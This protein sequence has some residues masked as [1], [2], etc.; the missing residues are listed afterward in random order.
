MTDKPPAS[1]AL[2]KLN[3]PHRV[4]RHAMPVTSFEQAA[5]DRDQRPEQIVRSILFQI[6]PEEFVMVLMA[7]R[8]QVD[9]RKLRKLVGRSRVRMAT[10][11]EVLQVTGY[12]I[13]TV[14][15]LGMSKQIKVLVDTSVLKE[16]EVSLGSGVPN[17]AIILKSAD[18]QHALGEVEIV[19]LA[20]K[21]E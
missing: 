20:E 19:E 11:D 5:S 6:R 18:L 21:S 16:T 10:E 2:E 17:T 13:G 15:P 9:W 12:R 7:G 8:E 4:F 3:I 1:I 14:S